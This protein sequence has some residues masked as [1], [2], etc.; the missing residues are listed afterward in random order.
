M[1]ISRR[2]MLAGGFGAAAFLS[3]GGAKAAGLL[4]K[5]RNLRIG[6]MSDVHVTTEKT[7]ERFI[8]ALRYLRDQDVD[9]VL[10]AG[11]LIDGGVRE[12]LEVFAGAWFEVF[13]ENRGRNGATVEKLFI[14][15]N[16][17]IGGHKYSYPPIKSKSKEWIEAN[18][19]SLGDNRK[20]I[21]EE[22]FREKW[23]PIWKKTVKG[24]IFV[25]GSWSRGPKHVDGAPEW[26]RAHAAELRGDRPFFYIQ[27]PHPKG[28]IPH[29]WSGDD[30]TVT[31]ALAEFPN[32]VA[33]TGHSHMPLVDDRSVWQGAFTCVNASS[34]RYTS[35]FGGRENSR[36]FG[37]EDPKTSQMF[38]IWAPDV[39]PVMVMDVYDDA[40]VFRRHDAESALKLAPDWVLPWR[41]GS[42]RDMS[43]AERASRMPLPRFATGA[44]VKVTT[45]KGMNRRKEKVDQVV[46]SFPNARRCDGSPSR[47]YDFEVVCEV[48]DVDVV[49]SHLVKRVFSPKFYQPE[50]KDAATVTC[51]FATSELPQPKKINDG[52]ERK[53]IAW[54]FTVRP[55]S[56]FGGRGDAIAT[57]WFDA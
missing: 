14:Y 20:R 52:P 45:R 22:L 38:A 35:C 17:D 6:I 30:G 25:G 41:D 2:S 40:L 44:Q 15:G 55:C 26:L 31:A 56:C 42:G 4:K 3:L 46:V 50:E 16:H 1:N 43:Y 47:A 54:R 37:V 39:A 53:T 33:V 36:E 11:D 5:P 13:P 9:G 10:I 28:T 19:L 18:A 27:H 32:A 48:R 7:A 23:E 49:K 8:K 34:L 21:W 24:Y 51:V 57:A 29:A 12:Q